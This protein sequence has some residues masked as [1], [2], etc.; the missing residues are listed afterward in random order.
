[1]MIETKAKQEPKGEPCLPV[2]LTPK[3]AAIHDLSGF[4]R[5]S[6]TVII[7]IL[8]AM[9]IQAC[10]VPTAILSTHT[11]GF[12]NMVF[13]DLTDY[14]D[15]CYA[16]YK[17]LGIEFDAIYSGFLASSAQID[18]CLKFFRGFP[19]ALKVVDPVMGDNGKP[20]KTYTKELCSRMSELV[21]IADII[22]PNL[23]EAAILLGED[24][25]DSAALTPKTAQ[26]WLKRLCEHAKIVVITGVTVD[27]QVCNIGLDRELGDIKRVDYEHIPVHYPGTGDIF[28]SVLTGA[29]LSGADLQTSIRRA[30]EFARKAVKVTYQANGEVGGNSE[31]TRNGVMFEKLL[32]QLMKL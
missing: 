25:P 22:T 11:G 6:L 27:N 17:T 10:P 28:A 19:S 18:G 30:T 1:M 29:I 23:T 21:G 5:C 13:K 12:D 4:G 3:V 14:L 31:S 26:D 24:F 8:S 20:Y 15:P 9:G 16:H 32:P 7:P 2:G